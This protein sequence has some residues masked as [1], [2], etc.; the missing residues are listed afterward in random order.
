MN[1]A[2][3]ATDPI[4]SSSLPSQEHAQVPS[5]GPREQM[6]AVVARSYGRPQD[7]HVALVDRPDIAADEVLVEVHAAGVDRCVWHL[8]TGDPYAVR[9]GFGLTKPKQPIQGLDV[10]GRV[11][12]VGAQV[13][14]FVPGDAVYGIAVS[15]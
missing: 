7:L 13:T 2:T 10:A 5:G 9:L 8:P 4:Q 15:T 3:T 11:V 6:R 1:T 12:V 14:R